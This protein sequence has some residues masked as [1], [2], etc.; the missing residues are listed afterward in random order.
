MNMRNRT[1]ISAIALVF[2]AQALWAQKPRIETVEAHAVYT[3]SPTMTPKEARYQTILSAQI[4][5]V[6]RTFGTIVGEENLSFVREKDKA[7]SSD[8]FSLHEGDVRGVWLESVG[9]TIWSE[10]KHLA[11]GSV[12]YEVRMEGKVMELKNAPIANEI[13]LLFNGTDPAKDEIRDFTFYDGDKMY[14]YF[15]SP[16]DGYLAVYIVDFDDNMSTQR[17]LPYEGEANG[18][19]RVMA[20]TEYILFS[21][22]KAEPSEKPLVRGCVMRGRTNHDFNQFYVIFSPNPFTKAIDESIDEDLP[23]VL[24]FKD[25]QKWLSKNRRRDLQMCVEKIFVDIIKK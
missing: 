19:H 14:L 21:K 4:D 17:I 20:D 23:S 13:K 5:A 2:C 18:I 8:F 16:V 22:E 25:F 24:S 9:D 12:I 11:D 6:A 3:A 15:K 1:I 10:P 7:S